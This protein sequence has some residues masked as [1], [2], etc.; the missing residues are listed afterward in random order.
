M[1]RGDIEKSSMCLMRSK[2]DPEVTAV[3]RLEVISGAAAS[4][5]RCCII[6]IAAVNTPAAGISTSW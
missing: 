3:H 6:L 2:L 4:A 1:R 5:M